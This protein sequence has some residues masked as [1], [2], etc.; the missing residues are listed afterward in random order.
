[1]DVVALV[2]AATLVVLAIA[3]GYLLADRSARRSA[4]RRIA[5]E[6]RLNR[7]R[8]YDGPDPGA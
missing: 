4:W 6:R 8:P 3:I 2:A 7:E 1:M 5:A